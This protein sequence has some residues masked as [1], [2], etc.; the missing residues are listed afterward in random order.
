MTG[1]A[2]ES[3]RQA[4][5]SAGRTVALLV[6]G[7]LLVRFLPFPAL[8]G[9]ANYL[10]LH[11]LLETFAIVVAGMVFVMGWYTQQ[12]DNSLRVLVLA[13][14]FLG[15]AILDFSHMMSYTGMPEFVTPSSPEKAINFWLM[16]RLLAALA[17]LSAA[18]LPDRSLGR[19]ARHLLLLLLASG[20]ALI[21]YWFLFVPASVPATFDPVTG[22][23][24]FKVISEYVLIVI[25]LAAALLLYRKALATLRVD[26]LALSAAAAITALAEIFFTFYT[27]VADLYNTVGH[28]YKIIAYAYLYNALVVYGVI[29]PYQQLDEL[30]DR[31]QSTVDA[32]PDMVFEITRGGILLAYHSDAARVNLLA[33][34]ESFVGHDFREFLF[35]PDAVAAIEQAMQDI[36]KTGSTSGRTYM[37]DLPDGRHWYELSG[38]LISKKEGEDSYLLLVRDVTATMIARR[39]SERNQRILRAAL[40]HMPLGVAVN[41]VGEEVRFEYMNDN[42]PRHYGVSRQALESS[43]D[44]WSL[45]YE[46]ERERENIKSR[47]IAD[48]AAGEPEHLKWEDVCISKK[49]QLPR[50]VTAQNIP[51]PEEGL[52][53][54]LVEDVTERLL[55]EQELRI[56]ATAFS[57]QEGIM[58]TDADQRILR[59]NEAF[60]HTTGYTQEELVGQKPAILSSGKHDED[61][62][63]AM[64]QSITGKGSWHGELWNRRKNGEIFPQSLTVTAVR[65]SAGEITHFVGDFIDL[66]EIKEAEDE[67]S[68]LSYYDPLTGLPNRQQFHVLLDRA[69][70]SSA[71]R[72]RIGALLMLDLDHFKT[73]NDT[74]GHEAGDQLLVQVSN[75]LQKSVR[76]GDVVA[77]YGGDE[78]ILILAQLEREP[79]KAAATV[80]RI[81]A[82]ILAAVDDTYSV[83]GN[84]YYTT[85][86]IG[87]T[88][89]DGVGAASSELLKQVEIALFQAKSVGRNTISFF[90]P[91]WQVAVNERAL[92][93]TEMREA[94]KAHQ[95]ELY[96]QRQQDGEGN[97]TG[98]EALVRWNHPSKGVLAPGE[99]IP[100]A[101]ESR[102]ISALGAE[103]M[104]MGLQ[105]LHSWQADA[106]FKNISLSIN[107]S[108]DQFYEADFA[109]RL[110]A[111]IDE[112]QLNPK[113]LTLEFTESLLMN[114][115]ELARRNIERLHKLGIRFAIDDFGTGYSSLSYLSEL[116]VD[117]LKIDQSFVRNSGASSKDAAIVKTIID[118]AG[119]MSME[120]LAEGVETDEQRQFLMEQGCALYQ[121]YLFG[122]PVPIDEFGG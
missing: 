90:D 35:A 26:Y 93:V 106:R 8:G 121:G 52:S 23:T 37:L 75:R 117:Q 74:L 57:S 3:F 99:F 85:C 108:V 109:D 46:D 49:G 18:L 43:S 27:D 61:F 79:D 45:V 6:L 34:P 105:Q 13:A 19:Y 72:Q 103:V 40:D 69:V 95:F 38:S 86:S 55:V 100:L 31:L 94:L 104:E 68:R 39:E 54:S 113:G 119:T 15:V 71:E 80:Q 25:Y 120:V 81:S 21:H 78:F 42:F 114:D 1:L 4:A 33:A 82:M 56:A 65:N 107:L 67:I 118:M 111:R 98:A 50:Y 47:V 66:T 32:I 102:L 28:V 59:V 29:A 51:V 48:V 76:A 2:H 17:L 97:L 41:S 115:L 101:E 22:L 5:G 110:I 53:V 84:D 16:A 122:R 88:L 20:L 116:S 12:T 14:L 44:F 60:S 70:S 24:E 10:P 7:L 91:E 73:I 92:M 83:S 64:W 36:G 96:Y 30:R 9:L 11:A 112:L 87:A 77:R 89:F 58:I 62:Y 63:R